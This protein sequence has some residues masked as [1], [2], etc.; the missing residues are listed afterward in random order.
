MKPEIR[1]V[2]LIMGG[3]K[4]VQNLALGQSSMDAKAHFAVQPDGNQPVGV[5]A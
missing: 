3:G 4:N 5:H 2:P 1:V